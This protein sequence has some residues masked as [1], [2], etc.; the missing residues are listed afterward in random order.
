MQAYN[1][2]DEKAHEKYKTDKKNKSN[3]MVAVFFS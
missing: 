2:K 1:T 3:E